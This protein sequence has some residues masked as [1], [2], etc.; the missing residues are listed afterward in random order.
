MRQQKHL[1]SVVGVGSFR[2]TRAGGLEEGRVAIETPNAREIISKPFAIA[3]LANR[4]E[5]RGVRRRAVTRTAAGRR[6]TSTS[7]DALETR[8]AVSSLRASNA[9]RL[10][11]SG[12]EVADTS[13]EFPRRLGQYPRREGGCVDCRVT[14][15]TS[16]DA[17]D[18][19]EI[20]RA[21]CRER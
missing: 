20:G 13:G 11:F 18:T 1:F 6:S 16:E 10:G 7:N 2:L 12:A 4:T 15:R 8:G 9:A 21:S 19:R 14:P 5:K 3:R 17:L